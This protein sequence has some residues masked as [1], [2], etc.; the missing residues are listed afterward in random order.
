M[1]YL[2]SSALLKLVHDEPETSALQ[3][4]LGR[5]P[6][7]PLISSELARV[8]VTRATRRINAAALPSAA[9]VIEMLD[10]IPMAT[11]LLEDAAT[12]GDSGLRSLDAIHL[13]SASAIRPALTALVAYDHRLAEAAVAAGLTVVAPKA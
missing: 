7:L 3:E 6:Q 5:H 8:E 10:L 1:I 13:A 11:G 9:A 12:I 2:D 4:W